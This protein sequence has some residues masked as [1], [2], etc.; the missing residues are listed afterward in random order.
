MGEI[1]SKEESEVQVV[2]VN[3]LDKGLEEPIV[4]EPSEAERSQ[5]EIFFLSESAVTCIVKCMELFN[6]P[7]IH[8]HILY[9][10]SF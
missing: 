9:V 8:P 3:D 4:E 5:D 2:E 1:K 6:K 7:M 10:F